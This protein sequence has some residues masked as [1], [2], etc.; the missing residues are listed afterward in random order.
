MQ[1][2]GTTPEGTQ[3]FAAVVA[4]LR[5]KIEDLRTAM[6]TDTSSQ[7]DVTKLR[8][9]LVQREGQ[10]GAMHAHLGVLGQLLAQKQQP[11]L[12]QG[13][14]S[15][16][17][18]HVSHQGIQARKIACQIE[19]TLCRR[20]GAHHPCHECHSLIGS[21]K[22]MIARWLT[23]DTQ[24]AAAVHTLEAALSAAKQAGEQQAGVMAEAY[25]RID[26]LQH[27]LEEEKRCLP[28]ACMR[29]EVVTCL[30]QN[31]NGRSSEPTAKISAATAAHASLDL[32]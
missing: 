12:E 23:A 17:V 16:R 1:D 10:G 27:L 3:D 19:A 28:N 20:M 31:C 11:A 22:C 6:Q 4:D 8:Q 21:S 29:L 5:Q 9:D 7:D 32:K 26:K 30:E 18:R 13:L 25:A 15:W 14:P 24:S 2:Q